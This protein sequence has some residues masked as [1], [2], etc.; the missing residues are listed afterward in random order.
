MKKR[1][2]TIILSFV[3]V[4]LVCP[5]T[6]FSSAAQNDDTLIVGVPTDRCPM[7]Y[8]DEVTG[9]I[10][11]IGVDLMTSA[12]RE[13]GY[14]VSF[15]E[16]SEPTLKA[17]LDN[18]QYD[19][20]MPFGSAI[21]SASG[22][23]SVVS[24]NLIQTPFT[25]VTKNKA[26]LPPMES[27]KV[28]ML[29]SLAGA[30][31]TVHQLYPGIEIDFYDTMPDCV[32]ALR[33]GEVDALLHNSYVWSYVLQKPSYSNLTVHSTAMFSMDF[34]AGTVDTEKGREII[35]R[36]NA[37][38]AT[39][40]D[41]NRQAAVLDY[42]TRRLYKYS[43]TDYLYEYR[44]FL[45][46]G[47]L[48]FAAFVWYV[49]RRQK[50]LHEQ[51][52]EKVKQLIDHDPLT[53]VLSL[54]GFRKRVQEL[55]AENPDIPY[56]ISY[57]NIKNFK[58]INDS[59]GKEA[60]DDLLRFWAEKSLNVMTDEEAIGRMES[61]HFIVLRKI[62]G[63]KKMKADNDM[64]FDPV[65]NYFINR[66]KDIRIQMSS[67]IYVLMPEDYTDPDVDH[68]L[69]YARVAEKQV[70]ESQKDGY[71]FYNPTQWE[72]GKWT[73]D[74][75]GHL[76]TA[77]ETNELLVWYQPQV[78]YETGQISGAEALC[79]WNHTKLGCIPPSEFIPA[80]EK[81]GS[82]YELDCYVWEKACQDLQRW[83][84]Q[85]KHMTVS[86]N[87]SRC[88]LHENRDIAAHFCELLRKYELTADQLHIE[89]TES[90]YVEDSGLLIDITRDLKKFGFQVEMDDFGSGYSSLNMLKE[91]PVD[92]IKLDL[93][94]LTETGNPE[95]GRIIVECMIHMAKL[96]G[97]DI[98]AEGVETKEQAE[99]LRSH[100]C[101]E[102]QGYYF[103]KPM[104]VDKF[105]A[106]QQ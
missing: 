95:K 43:F 10:T 94:F 16:L 64:V 70:K 89:I 31:E 61:D 11:G 85:G 17:S 69:D 72:K 100:G 33:K 29:S 23:A 82:V 3:V 46:W 86:V 81:S 55:L 1:F 27:M 75:V 6:A 52:E 35:D 102:M 42:T 47:T 49:A 76:R 99:F 7:F 90:A 56:F 38:I 66:G 26:A 44:F 62:G 50:K 98:I 8:K 60:G 91:V 104:P 5:A 84:Q 73:A 71:I 78:N 48:F 28:G 65:R 97:M 74:V 21:S 58:Y 67:G 34:R 68:M 57:N 15:R 2:I 4:M 40:S 83:N 22:Q 101:T 20:I 14:T 24:D 79:R 59:L 37:G 54:A 13:A 9:E 63:S 105:E 87:V 25:L 51:H 32:E 39:L 77:I 96:L 36:L 80:L 106:L 53:G 45:T 92:R 93:R 30:A 41:T 88:D 19:V 103:H 18:P 12:A